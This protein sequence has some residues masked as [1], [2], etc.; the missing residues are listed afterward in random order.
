MHEVV[1][2]RL[3]TRIWMQLVVVALGRR[4]TGYRLVMRDRRRGGVLRLVLIL[5]DGAAVTC[6]N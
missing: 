2:R 5:I 1:R 6:N 4:V 3:P